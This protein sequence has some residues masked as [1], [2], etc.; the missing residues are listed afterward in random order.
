MLLALCKVN[1]IGSFVCIFIE[2]FQESDSYIWYVIY[3]HE[4]MHARVLYVWGLT[5]YIH[6]TAVVTLLTIYI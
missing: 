5:I 2:C 6:R 1:T 4:C 3:I